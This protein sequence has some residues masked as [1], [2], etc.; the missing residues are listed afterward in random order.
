MQLRP[1][2]VRFRFRGFQVSRDALLDGVDVADA[3][4]KV[5]GRR[6]GTFLDLLRHQSRFRLQHFG[7]RG[8]LRLHLLAARFKVIGAGLQ[9]RTGGFG[10]GFE[11]SNVRFQFRGGFGH[12][13]A[14]LRFVVAAEQTQ[15]VLRVRRG[16]HDARLTVS[17][18]R[19]DVALRRFGIRLRLLNLRVRAGGNRVGRTG[20]LGKL[21]HT[22]G[23]AVGHRGFHHFRLGFRHRGVRFQLGFGLG[24]GV[25]GAR[26]NVRRARLPVRTGRFGFRLGVFKRGLDVHKDVVGAELRLGA[27]RRQRGDAR[28][29]IGFRQ[30]SEAIRRGS[31]ALFQIRSRLFNVRLRFRF[32]LLEAVLDVRRAHLNVRASLLGGGFN[33]LRGLRGVV[34]RFL[35][36]RGD[37][38]DALL[39]RFDR[40]FRR[41]RGFG[42]PQLRLDLGQRHVRLHLVDCFSPARFHVFRARLRVRRRLFGFCLRFR[43]GGLQIFN[44]VL[45]AVLNGL[46]GVRCG[47]GNRRPG[48]FNRIRDVPDDI[49]RR[50]EFADVRR[51]FQLIHRFR[52]CRHALYH[53]VRVSAQ[54]RHRI[55]EFVQGFRDLRSRFFHAIGFFLA[56]FRFR[57]N[58]CRF[59]IFVYSTHLLHIMNNTNVIKTTTT[60]E[61][62]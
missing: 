58:L 31:C 24:L 4:L 6:R 26:S 33:V 59:F 16:F 10:V 28:R 57:A 20:A 52:H 40:I 56:V 8:H 35:R 7:V 32:R 29:R 19:F 1:R 2:S 45:D 38:A 53:R 46:R 27:R 44:R 30:A 39:R 41:L 60:T 34:L 21:S 61:N 49:L 12:Q 62:V 36:A 25:R 42:F 3:L 50:S 22:S 14:V 15:R 9:L 43:H 47:V 23:D 18:A 13:I 5:F 55:R 17:D 54:I 51:R 48:A 37:V 11:L